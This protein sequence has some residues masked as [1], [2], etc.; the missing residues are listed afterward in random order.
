MD[1][2]LV[3]FIQHLNSTFHL[4]ETLLNIIGY[5]HGPVSRLVICTFCKL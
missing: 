5:Q 3:A 2:Q 1:F 4:E